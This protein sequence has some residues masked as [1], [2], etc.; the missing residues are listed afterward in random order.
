MWGHRVTSKRVP[1]HSGNPDTS[2]D[3]ALQGS[4]GL[5]RG[6]K[7]AGEKALDDCLFDLF[8]YLNHRVKVHELH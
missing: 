1:C 2:Y 6:R 4:K 8:G 3:G 7:T 5:R